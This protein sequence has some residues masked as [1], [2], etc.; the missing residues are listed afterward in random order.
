MRRLLL[1]FPNCTKLGLGNECHHYHAKGPVDKPHSKCDRPLIFIR[2]ILEYLGRETNV[3]TVMLGASPL[4][5]DISPT[6][7]DYSLPA[8]S[9]KNDLWLGNQ[10]HHRDARGLPLIESISLTFSL[11][12]MTVISTPKFSRIWEVLIIVNASHSRQKTAEV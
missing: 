7:S 4:I 2:P 6:F 11:G 3:T 5:V 1:N 8:V 10:C 9:S 12:M